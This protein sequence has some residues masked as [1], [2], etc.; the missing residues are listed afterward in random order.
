MI[1]PG[2]L[3]LSACTEPPPPPEA[4]V[5]RPAEI[6]IVGTG[7]L[8]SGLR[9]PG[10]VRAVKR[11]ELA[12][13]VSGELK[14]LLV[15]EGQTVPAGARIAAIDPEPFQ[16]RL[17]AA[18]AEYDKARM[19][20][21]RVQQIWERSQ[22]VARAEVDQKRTAMEVARSRFAAARKEFE[23][24][25]LI[26]PFEGVIARRY[27]EN[28][29]NVQAKEPIV[30]LQDL[31]ELEI[32]IHV[33]ER[34][35]H[36]APRRAVGVVVFEAL[37][38]RSFPVQLKTFSADADPQTQ[39]YEAVLSMVRPEGVTILPGMAAEVLPDP[40]AGG[41]DQ[42]LTVPL[43]AVSADADGQSQVWVV[44]PASG[45]VS[46]RRVEVDRLSGDV[47]VIRSGLETGEQIVTAGVQHLR[48]GM[49][50]RPL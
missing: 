4:D 31:S 24:S 34:I 18:R 8:D 16:L 38:G 30:S 46:A 22:A 9:F 5:V 15:R 39:T 44:D 13:N 28:F 14:E 21:E 37:P 11:V 41:A 17:D 20:H 40:A 48:D 19:D 12:F 50:V 29:Q 6:E 49:R 10:R 26:A 7:P 25:R 27:V 23:D 35:V 42:P 1:V 3:L 32:V 33:P 45:R 43:R 36:Q 2:V 47:A